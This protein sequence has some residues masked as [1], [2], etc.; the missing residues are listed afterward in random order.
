[1]VQ[2]VIWL[3][4]YQVKAYDV[5]YVDQT[6]FVEYYSLSPSF[7]IFSFSGTS[8]EGPSEGRS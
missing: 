7:Y 1:M 3:C 2:L 4:L 5:E 8:Q 6:Q